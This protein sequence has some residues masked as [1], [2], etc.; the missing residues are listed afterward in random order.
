VEQGGYQV[1]TG[2]LDRALRRLHT[3][4]SFGRAIID[5]ALRAAKDRSQQEMDMK[6][7]IS[8]PEPD[9]TIPVCFFLFDFVVCVSLPLT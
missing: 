8:A 5:A 3:P 7:N 4:E 1:A 2:D 9:G 6:I